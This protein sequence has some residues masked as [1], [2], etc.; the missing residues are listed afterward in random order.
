MSD[1]DQ[2]P[3]YWL[4]YGLQAF[5]KKP[6]EGA[7]PVYLKPVSDI[8]E[9]HIP[10]APAVA[11]RICNT[12]NNTGV[13]RGLHNWRTGD[14]RDQSC[15]N[16]RPEEPTPAVA[17]ETVAECACCTEWLEKTEWVQERGKWPF[18][19]LGMH[20]ADVM[21]KYIEHLESHTQTVAVN[22][23][24]EVVLHWIL[25]WDKERD[26]IMPYRLRD[27][28]RAVLKAAEAAKGGV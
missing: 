13:V 1:S 5:P 6:F 25:E 23:Q 14:K 24:M 16:C 2:K 27:P 20:R 15:W 9:R 19:E 4:G 22:E 26:Y 17:Q 21:K 18:Q 10:L 28:M 3:D 11:P 7:T 12:C 8:A